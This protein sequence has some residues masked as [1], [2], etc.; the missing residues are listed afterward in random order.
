M[1][2]Q[3]QLEANLE[4]EARTVHAD[5]SVAVRPSVTASSRFCGFFNKHQRDFFSWLLPRRPEPIH[6]LR[7]YFV[8]CLVQLRHQVIPVQNDKWTAGPFWQS[9]SSTAYLVKAQILK[10][11][12]S[13]MS[14]VNMPATAACPSISQNFRDGFWRSVCFDDIKTTT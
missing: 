6:F 13:T 11:I 9:P 2:S 3:K 10:G 8:R 14:G 4:K 1:H 5:S 12:S 7:P